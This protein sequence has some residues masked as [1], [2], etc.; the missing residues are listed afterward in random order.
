MIYVD[1]LT[2]RNT[3]IDSKLKRT[4]NIYDFMI[5]TAKYYLKVDL[6]VLALYFYWCNIVARLVR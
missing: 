4:L 5:Y 6:L 3:M 2:L 1:F